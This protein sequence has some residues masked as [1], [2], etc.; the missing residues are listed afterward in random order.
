M[1]RLLEIAASKRVIPEG[2][3]RMT[4]PDKLLTWLR[5]D[6]CEAR[7]VGASSDDRRKKGSGTPRCYIN[8]GGREA[9]R[10]FRRKR[11]DGTLP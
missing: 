1:Q 8:S 10:P 4:G 5:L 9:N 6:G 11:L 2:R 7:L 3:E